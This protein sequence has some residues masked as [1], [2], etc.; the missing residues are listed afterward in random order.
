[1]FLEN[2]KICCNFATSFVYMNI[3]WKNNNDIGKLI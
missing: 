3:Q 1:M 2:R